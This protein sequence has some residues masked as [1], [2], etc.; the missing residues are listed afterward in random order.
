MFI[1]ALF[2]GTS[3]WK[4]P[5]FPSMEEWINKVCSLRMMAYYPAINRNGG[6]TQAA[7]WLNLKVML[8]RERSQ[9]QQIT[10]MC[11]VQNS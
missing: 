5:T 2:I 4:Q 11:N 1:V 6:L 3:K 8:L 10:F 7:M 9:T